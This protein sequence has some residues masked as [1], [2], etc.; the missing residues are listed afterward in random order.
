[1]DLILLEKELN[2]YY[3]KNSVFFSESSFDKTEFIKELW[4]II[5][6]KTKKM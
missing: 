2:D 5:Y 4:S 3:H 6:E 1:M